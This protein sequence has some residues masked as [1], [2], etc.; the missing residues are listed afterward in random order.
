MSN[1]VG[2]YL[3]NVVASNMYICNKSKRN[4]IDE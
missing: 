1:V 3:I 2:P 4:D